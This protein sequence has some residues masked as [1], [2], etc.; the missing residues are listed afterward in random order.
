MGLIF[1]EQISA[2]IS[3]GFRASCS[4]PVIVLTKNDPSIARSH[5][6]EVIITEEEWEGIKKY[7]EKV[8]P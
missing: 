8:Y 4:K 6:M 5:T 3:M 7:M 1:F 2:E